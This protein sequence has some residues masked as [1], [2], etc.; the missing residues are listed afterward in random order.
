M[1]KTAIYDEYY[2]AQQKLEKKYGPQ[3]IVLMMVGSFYEMYGVDLPNAKPPLQI[4]KVEEAH[5]ILG[6][7]MTQRNKSQTHSRNNPYMAGFPDYA[8]DDHL[9]KLLRANFTVATYD[10]Y[11]VCY[12][13]SDGKQRV[14]KGRKLAHVYT[15]S[16][17]IDD[18]TVDANSLLTFELVEYRSPIT[19]KLL[20]KVHIAVLCL[21][22]GQVYLTEA[23]DTNEDTG[24]AESELYRI[25]HTFNPSEIIYC[26]PEDKKFSRVYDLGTKKVYFRDI[27]KE[28]RKPHYQNE[29][30]QKIFDQSTKK[31][32][33]FIEYLG[34][35]KHASVIPHFIQAL[36]FAFEQ[37]KLIV[38]RIHKPIFIEDQEQLI[39]N[40]DSIYQLNLVDSPFEVS[41]TV[42]DIVCKA[43]TAMGRRCVRQRLLTPITDVTELCR[44]Y[45]LVDHMRDEYQEYEEMLRGIADIEKKY[46]KMVL[47]TLHPYE[48]S[49]LYGT[50]IR[51]KKLLTRAEKLFD[52]DSQVLS[53]FECL[54]NEYMGNFNFSVMKKC[55]LKDIKGSFFIEGVNE[56]LDKME[57]KLTFGKKI[58]RDIAEDFSLLIESEKDQIV[59]LSCTDA[60][61]HFLKM[62]K[63]R[64]KL[65][66]ITFKIKFKYHGKTYL[67]CRQDLEIIMLKNDVKIFSAQI[68][69]ISQDISSQRS[70]MNQRITEEYLLL[71]DHYVQDYGDI[72]IKTA[73]II[74]N[75]DFIYSAAR[76]SVENGYIR[77]EIEDT[78][79]GRSYIDI[80]GLRHP[81]IERINDNEE[82]TPNDVSIG[83]GNHQGS[84]IYGLNLSGKSSLL[85]SI[86]CNIVLAQAGMFVSCSKFKYYP[87]KN[88]L[89]KMTIRDNISKGQSTFMIE[90]IE[91]KNMLMRADPNTLVL[92]DELCSS[93]ESTSGH[94][95]VA[96]TLHSLTEKGAKFVFSTHLHELQQIPSV[97][98]N[99]H[100]KIFHFKVHIDGETIVFDRK[101]EEGG[102][103]ELYGLEV[104]RAL[105]LS[106]DFMRGAFAIRDQ[107]TKQ[108]IEILTR[109]SSRYSSEVYMHT[110]EKCGSTENLNTHHHYPQQ[111]AD[112]NGM[113][114]KRF[115]K[116]CKFNLRVLCTKCHKKEHDKKGKTVP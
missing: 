57:T 12:I 25:I 10:Q 108:P 54:Y 104:A 9:G 87:F 52:I 61:G 33:S 55:K 48:L 101:I 60:N 31:L 27:P 92:S 37:D 35:E 106:N 62:T 23:Y 94:A 78:Q 1:I 15:P 30:L 17:Y 115:H 81:I 95:I 41:C 107:L 83:V 53:D 13:G 91:V 77:P 58:L 103:T 88:L 14:K 47:R 56:E 3:S 73:D 28:Y 69:M 51:I 59:K 89:S 72:L 79:T 71:L 105:G 102:M 64:F 109:K 99:E 86:G 16:T 29:F 4:G 34:L 24:K 80:T 98:K 36:Q 32:L 110:C 70:R 49:D 20:K 44:R 74:S 7:T 114:D 42:Y 6:M 19:K 38:N 46:R 11:D 8:I 45:N 116:N 43:K 75:I 63:R 66:P 2:M 26:G 96:Q 76:V 21:S 39:L 85:K 93:T 18:T 100:I 111:D 84:V 113:I 82:Y 90:M 67:I 22:T 40:N 97:S 112:K 65:L 50:F 5:N 68:N